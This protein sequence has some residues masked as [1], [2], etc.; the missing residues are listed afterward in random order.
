M[1]I[2]L[3]RQLL[4]SLLLLAY[5]ALAAETPAPA[6][7]IDQALALTDFQSELPGLA[8]Q[9]G[10]GVKEAPTFQLLPPQQQE[11]M[12]AAMVR[13][14]QPARIE[15]AV[16]NEIQAQLSTAQVEA[17]IKA[18]RTPIVE[19]MRI[20]EQAADQPQA[21][22][23]RQRFQQQSLQHP[24]AAERI[25]LLTRLDEATG[26]SA[27]IAD[28][29]TDLTRQLA[30]ASGASG[31]DWQAFH[32]QIAKGMRNDGIDTDLFVY[33]TL[34]N[35]ELE[36]YVCLHETPAVQRFFQAMG[37]GVA[38]AIATSLQNFLNEM[39]GKLQEI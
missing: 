4:L 10:Q 36:A 21:D 7:L 12:L 15:A 28:I 17:F 20:L 39:A 16:R 29:L 6:R 32:A 18:Y 11:R 30:K 3:T 5:P 14:F 33:R 22:A 31:Q 35:T 2:T 23:E 38:K 19:R 37:Q 24:P 27:V 25:T 34:N 13:Q 1:L 26:G 9:L 8:E